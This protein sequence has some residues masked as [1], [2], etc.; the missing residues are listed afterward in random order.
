M[1]AAVEAQELCPCHSLAAITLGASLFN[2]C[3]LDQ[4][5]CMLAWA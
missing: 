5:I 3:G 4:V 2:T 1:V